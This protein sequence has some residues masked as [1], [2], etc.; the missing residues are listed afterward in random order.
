MKNIDELRNEIDTIDKEIVELF[1]N[2]MAVS[3]EVAKYKRD[4]NK[5]VL[6]RERER[7]LLNKVEELAGNDL[8]NY[9]RKLF[10]TIMELSKAYQNKLLSKGVLSNEIKH[11][12]E[13]T[14]QLFP[15][16]AIVACQGTEGAYSQIATD[17]IIQKPEIV[18][19]KTFEN[20]FIAVK[21][22]IA[23]FGIVPLENSTAG[24]VNQIYQLMSEYDFSI[25]ASTKIQ[26]SHCLLSKNGVKL[27]NIKEIYSHQQAI[28]QCS[29]FL[30]TLSKDVKITA[31]ENTA[32]AARFLVRSDRNDIASL[33]SVDC[34]SLYGLEIL[35]TNVQ[36]TDNNYTRFIC[37]SKNI[38]IYPGADKTSLLIKLPHHSG[39]LYQIIS[40]FNS[41]NLNLLKLES[42]AIP[43]SDFEFMFYFDV[44]V[45]I[46]S[47]E[48]L[49]MFNILENTVGATNIKYL[50]SYREI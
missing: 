18:Y 14:Q 25:T 5:P 37:F 27:E 46:Y 33:S 12:I 24:S 21:D 31:C 45:S 22:G 23:D 4:N 11:A 40:V 42:R 38:Q 10:C 41:L 8:G 34:A 26:I 19:C 49:D 36:N 3:T 47:P 28:D 35:K 20:V 7:M 48:F 2:R 15:A 29:E 13:N 39:S 50:G 16:K 9:T 32:E 6:D 30:S 44:N 43:G 17:K 1:K